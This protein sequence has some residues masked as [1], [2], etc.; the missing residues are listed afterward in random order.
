MHSKRGLCCFDFLTF[1]LGFRL[2]TKKLHACVALGNIFFSMQI[3]C[4]ALEAMTRVLFDAVLVLS[5][6]DGLGAGMVIGLPCILQFGPKWMKEKVGSDVLS[7]KK[8]ICLAITEPYG[9][10]H[11]LAPPPFVQSRSPFRFRFLHSWVGR[12]EPAMHCHQVS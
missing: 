7:G 8:R 2:R 6:V 3:V 12:R 9:A 5:Y 11:L 1:F 10:N 4:D